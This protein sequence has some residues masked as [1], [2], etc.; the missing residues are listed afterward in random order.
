MAAVIAVKDEQLFTLAKTVK[1]CD[2]RVGRGGV[3]GQDVASLGRNDPAS[4]RPGQHA[5]ATHRAELS[6]AHVTLSGESEG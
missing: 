4:A 1:G 3:L 6:R 5:Q 2:L